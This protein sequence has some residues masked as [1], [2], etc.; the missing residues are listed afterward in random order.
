VHVKASAT[1]SQGYYDVKQYKPCSYEEHSELLDQRKQ[2]KLQWLQNP[3]HTN[4]D[5]LNVV[6]CDTSRMFRNKKK[7]IFKQR[8]RT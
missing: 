2:P 1:E 4:G 5:N 7:I 3:S 8:V 6:R